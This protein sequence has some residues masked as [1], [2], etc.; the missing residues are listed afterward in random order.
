MTGSEAAVK[1]YLAATARLDEDLQVLGPL[2]RNNLDQ[3]L[4]LQHL[5]TLVGQKINETRRIVAYCT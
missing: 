5:Q 1:P 2:T 3:Q 4:W